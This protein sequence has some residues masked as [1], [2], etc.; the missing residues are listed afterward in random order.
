MKR[1]ISSFLVIFII[2]T[3]MSYY[4]S[5]SSEYDNNN[6]IIEITYGEPQSSLS[7]LD[8]KEIISLI[9]AIILVIMSWVLVDI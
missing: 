8:K 9:Y 5:S 7:N 6:Q 2:I 4:N 1:L 3:C